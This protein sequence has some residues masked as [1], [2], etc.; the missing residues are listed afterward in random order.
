MEVDRVC[1]TKGTRNCTKASWA[2][3]SDCFPWGVLV[4]DSD[5]PMYAGTIKGMGWWTV[6]ARFLTIG[7]GIHGSSRGGGQD[8]A[9]GNGLELETS[10]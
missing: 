5:A 8:D 7:M 3:W 6:G 2:C 1:K 10:V 4:N 9:C